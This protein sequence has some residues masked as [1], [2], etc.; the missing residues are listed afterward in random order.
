MALV[1]VALVGGLQWGGQRRLIYQPDG[2]VPDVAAVMGTAAREV[3]Y[4]SED[5]VP[6]RGWLVAP[7]G[8]DLGAHVLVLPGN[9]GNRGDR[10]GLAR[11]LAAAGLT[12]LLVDYR[13]YG[14]NPGSPSEAGLRA[15]ARAARAYLVERAGAD[16]G[17]LVYL[18]ESLGSAV[19]TGLA[20][21]HPSAGLVLR[22]PFT[23]LAD[24][25]Q[26]LYPIHP[27][28]LL[29]WDRFPVREWITGVTAPT[30]VVYGDADELVPA[31]QSRA[32]AD[33]APALVRAVAVPGAGHNDPELAEG[34]E[35]VAAV[36]DLVRSRS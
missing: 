15:D 29:L 7:T 17:R 27:M 16:P 24:V 3:S 33:A 11:R 21:E 28:R 1:A 19:A 30:A 31:A 4:R 20:V 36:A 12:V 10:A 26:R 32:V 5:D 6:L 23:S 9:A 2:R 34:P 14:G 25:A 8:P 18:G 35:L 13:G 22:S